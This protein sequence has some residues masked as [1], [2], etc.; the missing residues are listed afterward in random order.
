MMPSAKIGEGEAAGDR[1]Q[2]LGRLGG[3]LDV[4]DA[5][6]V[7]RRRGRQHDEQ[8]DDVGEAHAD[9]RIELHAGHLRAA[10]ARA[11][12]SAA[13]RSGSSFSSSTSSPA[14]QKNRYGLIVVPNTA[15]TT[16]R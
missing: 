1:A 3:G 4:G 15:T 10:P 5:V 13:W 6:R 16:V 12:R 14:C 11:P 2:R 8:R 7:Q 9:E